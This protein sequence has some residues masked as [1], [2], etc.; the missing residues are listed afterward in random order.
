MKPFVLA[1]TF[2]ASSLVSTVAFACAKPAAKPEIPDAA[3][4][5]TAQMV[6]ANND[7]KAYVKAVQD[8]VGCA[9]LS[10]AEEKKEMDELQKFAE[11]FNQVVR[12]YKARSAG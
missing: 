11:D 10:R 8:Y 7:V 4:V 12:A 3:T 1:L 2:C 5:V 9:G 6:K